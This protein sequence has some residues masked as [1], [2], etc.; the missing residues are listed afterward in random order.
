MSRTQGSDKPGS[1]QSEGQDPGIAVEAI[2]T[3]R[4]VREVSPQELDRLRNAAG[5][6]MMDFITD[7][8]DV[9]NLREMG[10]AIAEDYG[11]LDFAAK[12]RGKPVDDSV[13]ATL[14]RLAKTRIALWHVSVVVVGGMLLWTAYEA[15]AGYFGWGFRMGWFGEKDSSPTR[16]LRART[17]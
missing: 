5:A 6:V 11:K 2:G 10:A 4:G 17:A 12:L 14:V 16:T 1:G 8:E 7:E 15:V 13:K 9:K 3:V